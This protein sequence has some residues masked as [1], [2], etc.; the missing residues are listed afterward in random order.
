VY[1][2]SGNLRFSIV[3]YCSVKSSSNVLVVETIA[4]G[5]PVGYS[6][7]SL[8]HVSPLLA[9]S[10][11]PHRKNSTTLLLSCLVLCSYLRHVRDVSNMASALDEAMHG[12][13][14]IILSIPAPIVSSLSILKAT[15]IRRCVNIINGI[16]LYQ[17]WYLCSRMRTW[18]AIRE[19]AVGREGLAESIFNLLHLDYVRLLCADTPPSASDILNLVTYDIGR[20]FAVY[21]TLVKV[22][23][24]AT[25]TTEFNLYHGSATDQRQGIHESSTIICKARQG[26][27]ST[28]SS[29][30]D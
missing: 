29:R 4:A 16:C 7:K 28:V 1:T 23:N 30:S 21:V 10:H 5:L 18:L 9:P 15:F 2:I 19:E 26:K 6:H 25:D 11:T 17:D 3:T 8:Q 20:Y 13:N 22:T 27:T 14:R 24:F 12:E